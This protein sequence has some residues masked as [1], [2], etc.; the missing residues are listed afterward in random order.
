MNPFAS[1]SR[2]DDHLSEGEKD[3]TFVLC[4]AEA[5]SGLPAGH[6]V[7][8]EWFCTVPSC[9]CH[10]IVFKVFAREKPHEPLACINYGWEDPAYYASKLSLNPR[11]VQ[12]ITRAS[13]ESFVPQSPLAPSLLQALREHLQQTP[14]MRE[15]LKR[16]YELVQAALLPQPGTD[17]AEPDAE[18][19]YEAEPEAAV[20]DAVWRRNNDD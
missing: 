9:D 5:R 19:E 6:Y 17:D 2:Y 15:Q 13:L 16:H 7:F 12:E 18:P 1:R 11:E 14:A 8:A 4:V 10:R 3:E 20:E